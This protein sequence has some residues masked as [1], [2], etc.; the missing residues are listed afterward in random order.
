[1]ISS[2]H[3]AAGILSST[4]SAWLRQ[5][6]TLVLYT[7]AARLLEPEQIGVFALASTVLLLFEYG[8]FDSISETMV[9]RADLEGG[10]V[11]AALVMGLCAA[12]CVVGSA[13][14]L[15]GTIARTFDFPDVQKVLPWM[16]GG[17]ALICISAVHSGIL[18]RQARFHLISMISAI[19]G[20]IACGTGVALMFMGA[21]V[22]SLVAYFMVEKL[23]LAGGTIAAALSHPASRFAGR[24]VR[25]IS[26]YASAIAGQR[27]AFFLRN[28]IDR[29]LIAGLW[30]PEVLGAY[31][32]AGRVFESLLA[33]LLA[34]AS[35]MFFV[36]YARLQGTGTKLRSTFLNSLE[37]VTFVIFPACL[38]LSAV[39]PEVI[40]ILFGEGWE[41]SQLILQLVAL[42][43]AP[44]VVNVMSGA[45]ISAAGFAR[46][47]LLVEVSSAILG[48]VMLASMS[49]FG[50]VGVAAA[51]IVRESVAVMIYSSVIRSSFSI[52]RRAYFGTFGYPLAM[53]MAMLACAEIARKALEN[54]L[55]TPAMLVFLVVFGAVFYITAMAVVR[56]PL[57]ER[58]MA[59]VRGGLSKSTDP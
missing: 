50:I 4:A 35:K 26:S 13:T 44:L 15:A 40:R 54:N 34:P 39:G 19:A 51:I 5:F 10:H 41:T 46:T 28:Q 59:L 17:V 6:A 47:F 48:A 3:L 33:V 30:G 58:A 24:H 57:L 21:G 38:G 29:F 37:A 9:Q 55:S 7:I 31:Q 49:H 1:M 43:G 53:S 8:V 20:V 56:M 23:V 18:R 12:L 22:W 32:L 25:E 45:L 36:S 16:A 2:K 52:D 14:L 11:G 42:G 27:A